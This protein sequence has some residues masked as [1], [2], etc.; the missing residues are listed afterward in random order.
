[1]GPLPQDGNS[2]HRRAGRAVHDQ[3]R[4][5]GGRRRPAGGALINELRSV[6]RCGLGPDLC[7][8]AMH[9]GWV[10]TEMGGE[11]AEIDVLTSTRGMLDQVKAQSGNAGLRFINYKGEALV[12]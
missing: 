8:L 3:C 10:K 7:V 9:P 12:W 6:K 2:R 1:M 5:T 11:N 4:G